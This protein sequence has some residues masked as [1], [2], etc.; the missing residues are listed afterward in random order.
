MALQ[1]VGKARRGTLLILLGKER[2]FEMSNPDPK[3]PIA[4]RS[5]FWVICAFGVTFLLRRMF[6]SIQF[7]HRQN[8]R[9]PHARTSPNEAKNRVS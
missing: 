2:A 3:L 4:L 6:P 1:L 5:D 7:S 8:G 9:R